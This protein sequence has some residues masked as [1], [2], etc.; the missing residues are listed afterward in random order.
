[1]LREAF[2]GKL[3]LLSVIL[4]TADLVWQEGAFQIPDGSEAVA[5]PPELNDTQTSQGNQ[6]RAF[7]TNQNDPNQRLEYQN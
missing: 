5:V 6:R 1:M 4:T 3:L 7:L 2:K